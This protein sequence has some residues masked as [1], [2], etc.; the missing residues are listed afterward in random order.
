MARDFIVRIDS[1]GHTTLMTLPETE[2]FVA[3]EEDRRK[4]VEEAERIL[5]EEWQK[6]MLVVKVAK[7]K[8]EAELVQPHD[9]VDL[10]VDHYEVHSQIR[11]G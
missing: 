11:G 6:G 7:P 3:P 2:E 5:R 10:K 1:A 4:A 9:P 8:K